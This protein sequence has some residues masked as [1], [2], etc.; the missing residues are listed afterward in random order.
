MLRGIFNIIRWVLFHIDWQRQIYCQCSENSATIAE[1]VKSVFILVV[2]EVMK[3]CKGGEARVNYLT[4]VTE[5]I[6]CK[7]YPNYADVKF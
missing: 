5:I 1:N 4:K 6:I 3:E 7:S 2:W